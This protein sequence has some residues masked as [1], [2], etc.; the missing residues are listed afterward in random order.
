M[1]QI[2][3]SFTLACL[4]A[5]ALQ[6]SVRFEMKENPQTVHERI[7]FTY[8][9]NPGLSAL[10][11]GKTERP[12]ERMTAD[13]EME[14]S[15]EEGVKCR[16]SALFKWNPSIST[17][18]LANNWCFAKFRSKVQNFS[19]RLGTN[20]SRV[21]SKHMSVNSTRSCWRN[22]GAESCIMTST[23]FITS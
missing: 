15:W 11:L 23:L 10:R 22:T 1:N 5:W 7:L 17:W 8:K 16:K 13:Q 19:N 2:L 6:S 4:P 12:Q 18:D 3:P 20:A 21:F 9:K 14:E